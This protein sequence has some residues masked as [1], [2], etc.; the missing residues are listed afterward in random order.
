MMV[1]LGIPHIRAKVWS[2]LSDYVPTDQEVVDSTLKRKRGEYIDL[3]KHYF[4]DAAPQDTV[5]Q[6]AEKIN[7]MSSYENTNFKQIRIDVIRTQPEVELFSKQ[8]IQ[9]MMIRILFIWSMRHPA[10]AYV[11]GINDLAAPMVVIF[12]TSSVF[13]QQNK[14]N[15]QV[16]EE[17]KNE[18][19]KQSKAGKPVTCYEILSEEDVLMLDSDSFLAV[20]AD[21][22]WC[23]SKLIDDI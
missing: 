13:L 23:L 2:L 5:E 19:I 22:F 7:D 3:V 18:F 14:Q 10:S 12:L 20:E 17:S 8:C 6:L 16:A 1:W 4:N 11:Q 9:T 21:A 15:E